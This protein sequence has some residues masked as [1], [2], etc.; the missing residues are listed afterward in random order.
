LATAGQDGV[1]R[2]HSSTGETLAVLPGTAPWAEHVAWSPDGAHVATASGRVVRVWTASGDPVCESEPHASTITG[3]TWNN[4][5]TELASACYSGV[6]LWPARAGARAKHLPWKGSLISLARSPNDKVIACGT[7]EC[8][9]HFWRLPDGRDSEMTGFPAKPRALSWEASGKLLAASGDATIT[10]WSFERK[11]PE[12]TEPAEL[13]AHQGLCTALAFHPKRPV[14]ASGSEDTGVILWNPRMSPAP[15][16]FG[17]LEDHVTALAWTP[18]GRLL[19]GADASGT[20]RCW[21]TN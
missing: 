4:V 5:G 2:L 11:G 18:G 8:S 1:A 14:L 20:V 21:H 7:Q 3:L 9:V 6:H 17:F 13:Q 15:Q 16:A 19:V 10:V 12:G